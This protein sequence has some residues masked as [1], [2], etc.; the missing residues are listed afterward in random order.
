MAFAVL[1]LSQIVHTF[2][3]RS[4]HSI[5]KAGIAANPKLVLAAI[6][7]TALQAAV[8]VFQPL[9]VIFKT[10]VLNPIQWLAVIAI[11]FVPLLVVELEKAVCVNRNR[12][13]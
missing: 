4:P 5:F 2:N 8:I 12:C 3:M 6:I 11:S 9:A 1:S 7:C 13:G 10:A